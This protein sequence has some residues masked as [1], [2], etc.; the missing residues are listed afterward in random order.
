[1]R[2]KCCGEFVAFRTLHEA[3]PFNDKTEDLVC[4]CLEYYLHHCGKPP[5]VVEHFLALHNICL[6]ELEEQKRKE[7]RK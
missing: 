5:D 6:C 7:T 3:L 1:M 4:R 2:D